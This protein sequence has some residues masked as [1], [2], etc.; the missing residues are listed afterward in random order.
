MFSKL[1]IKLKMLDR[2]D[3]RYVD[4]I[5]CH[6]KKYRIFYLK[7]LLESEKRYLILVGL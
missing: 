1:I 2:N 4:Y 3:K 5:G 7:N 6:K